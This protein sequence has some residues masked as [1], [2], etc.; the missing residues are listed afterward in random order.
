MA[1]PDRWSRI[2]LRRAMRHHRDVL[3]D[4]IGWAVTEEWIVESSEPGQGAD[5]RAIHPGPV[6]PT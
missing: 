6:S 3:D 4:A 2:D 5:R 1:S